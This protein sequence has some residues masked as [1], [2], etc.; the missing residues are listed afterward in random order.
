MKTVAWSLLSLLL[1][2][3]VPLHAQRP[4]EG[5]LQR[6]IEIRGGNDVGGANIN[7]LAVGWSLKR[8]HRNVT[9][10]AHLAN[11]GGIGGYAGGTAYITRK[12][13][14]HSRSSHEVAKKEFELPENYSGMFTLFTDLHLAAGEYWLVFEVPAN[15]RFSY[16]NWLV[17]M[18]FFLNTSKGTRYLGTTASTHPGDAAT[19]MPATLIREVDPSYGYQFQVIGEPVPLLKDEDPSRATLR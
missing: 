6:A 17:A 5:L 3:V 12:I 11:G 8:D 2:G 19:Y 1:F 4:P 13:G 16:A 9:V 14:P 18:P 10:A 7:G 15:G